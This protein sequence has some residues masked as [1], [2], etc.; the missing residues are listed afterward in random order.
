MDA[1]SVLLLFKFISPLKRWRPYDIHSNQ[2]LP[3]SNTFSD[4]S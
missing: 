4:L 2:E 3:Q 1:S